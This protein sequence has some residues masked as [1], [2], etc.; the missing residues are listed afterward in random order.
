MY[1]CF[2]NSRILAAAALMV[3]TS[4]SAQAAPI[5]SD[6]TTTT[7]NE[8]TYKSEFQGDVLTLSIFTDN[9]TGFTAGATRAPVTI[10]RL[11]ALTFSGLRLPGQANRF[12][13]LD[14]AS[15]TGSSTKDGNAC[16]GANG[17]GQICFDTLNDSLVAGEP[18]IY[19][20]KFYYSFGTGL[21]FDDFNVRATFGG[22]R[23]AP[24][25]NLVPVENANDT[26]R[27]NAT[28]VPEPASLAL[29]GLGAGAIGF[30]RRRKTKTA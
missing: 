30:T 18:L 9:A 14:S 5:F 21:D 8:I 7:D 22:T 20:I 28:E 10:N 16:N 4:V 13:I 24:N 27:L 3:S 17:G 1:K 26:A 25:G 11:N 23:V 6:G 19:Q 15:M 12:F 29:L 2:R